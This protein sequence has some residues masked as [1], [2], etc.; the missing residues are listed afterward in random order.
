MEAKIPLPVR[1]Q[2]LPY[3]G[4]ATYHEDQGGY[5]FWREVGMGREFDHG[6]T[7]GFVPEPYQNWPEEVPVIY[8]VEVDP[9]T[10]VVT[11]AEP[12][13]LSKNP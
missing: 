13:V 10:H 7:L 4:W 9:A 6:R 1:K 2:G 12:W 8:R 3:I 11:K 5:G